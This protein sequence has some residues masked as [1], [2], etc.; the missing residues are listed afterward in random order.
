MCIKY[1]NNYVKIIKVEW[2]SRINTYKQ[3]YQDLQLFMTNKLE[4]FN[5]DQTQFD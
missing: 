2:L 5:I 3:N 1:H 4:E